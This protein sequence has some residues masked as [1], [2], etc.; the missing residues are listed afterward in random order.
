MSRVRL[1]F[2]LPESILLS[3]VGIALAVAVV[4][5]NNQV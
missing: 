3:I 2:G 4:V 1:S 5:T